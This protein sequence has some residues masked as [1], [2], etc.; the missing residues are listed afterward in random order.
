MDSDKDYTWNINLANLQDTLTV[1]ADGTDTIMLPNMGQQFSY[2]TASTMASGPYATIGSVQATQYPNVTVNSGMNFGSTWLGPLS[3]GTS[4]KIQLNGEDADVEVNG[5]S[6]V[7]AVKRIE[8]RLGLYQPNHEL[9]SE[10]SEL[11]E[12]SEQYRKLEQH[13]LDKQAT[14]DRIRAMPAPEVD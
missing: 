5:W 2:S 4:A 14:W 11:R 3:T 9:E 13:I 12:L 6:L 7:D 8:Q 10:W 1:N